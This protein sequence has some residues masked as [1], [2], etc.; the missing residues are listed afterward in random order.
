LAVI[1]IT[2]GF[3]FTGKRLVQALLPRNTVIIY[4]RNETKTSFSNHENFLFEQG[5]ITNSKRLA[6]VIS[7]HKPSIIIHLAA[8]TGISKCENNPYDSFIT[9]VFGTFNVIQGCRQNNSSLIFLSSREV[10]GETI[11]DFSDENDDTIPNNIYGLTKLESE[12]LILWNHKKFNLNYTILRPS[13]IYGPDG[14]KYGVQIIIK[15][16]IQNDTIEIMGGQQKMNF[17][18]IDDV[19]SAILKCINNMSANN[20]IFNVASNDN[21]S[22]NEL[23]NLLKKISEKNPQ[24]EFTSVRKGETINFKPSIEKINKI[25]DWKPLISLHDGLCITLEEYE[26]KFLVR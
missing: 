22:V 3:G 20:Q 10:Y 12:N 6:E 18:F 26:S 1:L 13:N 21:I 25:L 23:I 4:S 24:L 19:V 17:I 15:K 9:N 5:D 8:I 14:D 2:G 11:G 16:L 7:T